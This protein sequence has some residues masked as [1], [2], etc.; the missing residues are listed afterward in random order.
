MATTQI[1]RIRE[2][3]E[4]N[5]W[6]ADERHAG[7]VTFT[8]PSRDPVSVSFGAHTGT[9]QDVTGGGRRAGARASQVERVAVEIHVLD[10]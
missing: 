6:A 9:V 1:A 2:D 8:K 10:D 7:F 5:G 3:A 4:R